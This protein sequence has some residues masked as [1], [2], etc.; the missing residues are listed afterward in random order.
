MQ[1]EEMLAKVEA[2]YE[3]RRSG[4]FAALEAVVAPGAEFSFGGEQSLLASVPATVTGTG[5]VHEVARELF[6]SIEIRELERVQAVAEGNR[7]AILWNTTLARPGGQPFATQMFDLWEFDDN[8]R[9][10]RGTQF[11]D[12]AKIVAEMQPA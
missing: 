7:V 12:T 2:A 10:C 1:R 9:I 11:V 8:G 6:E 5:N 3:A 4:D